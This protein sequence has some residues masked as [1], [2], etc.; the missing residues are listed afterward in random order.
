[1]ENWKPVKDYE[2]FYEVSDLGRVR[3][4]SRMINSGIKHNSET[5]KKGKVLKNNL[6]RNGYLTCDLSKNNVVKTKTIHRL[7]ADAFLEKVEGKNYV[8]H[9]NAIK[10]DN[11][12]K[13]LE[14]VTCKENARHAIDMGLIP[15]PLQCKRIL[16]VEAKLE[17]KSSVEAARWL[18]ETKHNHTK[19]I[20]VMAR[21]IRAVCSGKRE[22]TNGYRWKDI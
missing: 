10:T 14:W 9:K 7:I 11:R 1:M 15:E 16:C 12:A 20:L 3:S 22:K 8:N 4:V 5:L 21:N 13:N 18:N 2:G 19:N 6:K 17:F